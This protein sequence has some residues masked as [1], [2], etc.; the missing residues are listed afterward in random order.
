MA[1]GFVTDVGALLRD[2]VSMALHQCG[3][4]PR[5]GARTTGRLAPARCTPASL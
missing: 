2:N 1:I 3:P 4:G 5:A